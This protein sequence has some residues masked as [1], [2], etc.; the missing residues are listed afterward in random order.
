MPGVPSVELSSSETWSSGAGGGNRSVGSQTWI[1]GKEMNN[2]CM[3]RRKASAG[4]SSV[5][6]LLTSLGRR[7]PSCQLGHSLFHTA[8]LHQGAGSSRLGKTVASSTRAALALAQAK[9]WLVSIYGFL[10]R[11]EEGLPSA[12]VGN[13]TVGRRLERYNGSSQYSS[14]FV[15]QHAVNISL[16]G[17]CWAPSPVFIQARRPVDSGHSQLHRRAA[18]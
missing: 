7:H 2:W 3:C 8:A 5:R 11:A 12:L 17:L 15:S 16:S 18:V 4:R 1:W 6:A 9:T 10:R 13:K 14:S